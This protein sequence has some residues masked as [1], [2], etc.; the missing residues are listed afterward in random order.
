MLGDPAAACHGGSGKLLLCA[1]YPF[2]NTPRG[3]L[4]TPPKVL[5]FGWMVRYF[6]FAT[7]FAAFFTGALAAT[8]LVAIFLFS[9]F[10]ALHRVCNKDIAV[11]ECIDSRLLS[12][13]RKTTQTTKKE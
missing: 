5:P 9:L 8:F 7:F 1:V 2:P 12:V 13:K 3:T 10:D 11:E 4:L 6:F